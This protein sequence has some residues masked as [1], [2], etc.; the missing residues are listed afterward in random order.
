MAGRHPASTASKSVSGFDPTTI[1]GC[2]LWLDG[3]EPNTLESYEGTIPA[4]INDP[5]SIWQNKSIINPSEHAS[6]GG[7]TLPLR[8]S[9]NGVFFTG[10]SLLATTIVPIGTADVTYFTV[11]KAIIKPANNTAGGIIISTGVNNADSRTRTLYDYSDSVITSTVGSVIAGGRTYIGNNAISTYPATPHPVN[12][13]PLVT[14]TH[15]TTLCVNNLVSSLWVS[16]KPGNNT[17]VDLQDTAKA[18][19]TAN[20]DTIIGG[21][22]LESPIAQSGM[23]LDYYVG[24]IYE[25]L[26]YNSALSNT[27]RQMVE[28]Y[29]AFKW[30]LQEQLPA[31]HPYKNIVR[32]LTRVF[33][34]INIDGCQ[35]W[36]DPSD[37]NTVSLNGTGK[38]VTIKDKSGLGNDVANSSS[39]IEVSTLNG[40]PALNFPA[41]GSNNNLST[42]VITRNPTKRTYFFVIKYGAFL[43]NIENILIRYEDRDYFRQ[44]GST[45]QPKTLDMIGDPSGFIADI[46]GYTG[47]QNATQT[48]DES[49]NSMSAD[50]F[51]GNQIFVLCCVRDGEYYTFSTNGVSADFKGNPIGDCPTSFSYIIS[52]SGNSLVGDVII[53]NAAL[54]KSDLIK[55]EGYLMWKWGVRREASLRI[56]IPSKHP[57]YNFPPDSITPKHPELLLYKKEFNPS[58]LSPV[59]WIDPQDISKT[60][61]ISSG[62]VVEIKNKG[63]SNLTFTPPPDID[64]PL[65]TQSGVKNGVGLPFLDFSN[66]GNFFVSG[67]QVLADGITLEL[68]TSTPH[69][70]PV[71]A[72]V[73]LTVSSGKYADDADATINSGPFQIVSGTTELRPA[74]SGPKGTPAGTTTTFKTVSNNVFLGTGSV[75][76][77]NRESYFFDGTSATGLIS[78][79]FSYIV[80]PGTTDSFQISSN[81]TNPFGVMDI[82]DVCARNNVGTTGYY[83]TIAGTTASTIRLTLYSERT[84]GLLKN[85]SASI[86]YGQI[87]F[88]SVNYTG[89]SATIST[90]INHGIPNGATV[91]V[92]SNNSSY[93]PFQTSIKS[94]P[95][96]NAAYC[97]SKT[98]SYTTVNTVIT[99]V[100][101]PLF[102]GTSGSR[103]YTG[104]PV[105]VTLFAG[106]VI[107]NRTVGS[108]TRTVNAPETYFRTTLAGSDAT[109]VV[110]EMIDQASASSTMTINGFP[111]TVDTITVDTPYNSNYINTTATVS[112]PTS[113][114]I[115]YPVNRRLGTESSGRL[116]N[117]NPFSLADTAD[118]DHGYIMYPVK[119]YALENLALGTALNTSQM[120]IIWASCLRQGY[121]RNNFSDPNT[122]SSVISAATT[123]RAAG[124]GAT[125][126]RD[127]R[128]QTSSRRINTSR[129]SI[130]RGATGGDSSPALV[131]GGRVL[132]S[133]D[134]HFR[135]NNVVMNF[136]SSDVDDVPANT[137]GISTNGWG[138][139]PRFQN[140]AV[141]ASV[142]GQ[143]NVTLVPSHL[144]I[145][146]NTNVIP[147]T[148][149]TVAGIGG[150]S[151]FTAGVTGATAS[152]LNDLTDVLV[153]S[154]GNMYIA[155][156]TN[157]RVRMV[158]AVDGTYFGTTM[159]ANLMYTI[160]GTGVAGFLGD[161]GSAISARLNFPSRVALDSA[162]NLYIADRDNQ[163]IRRVNSVNGVITTIAGNGVTGFGGDG[164]GATGAQLNTPV[165]VAVDSSGNTLIADFGNHRIRRVTTSGTI[166]TVAGIT[167][168]GYNGDSMLAINARLN[169]PVAVAVDHLGHIYIADRDNNRIRRI[170]P[171]GTIFTAAGGASTTGF[172]GDGLLATSST[173]RLNGPR[174]V[175][176]DAQRNIYIADLQNHR[177]RMVPANTGRFFGQNMNANFIYTIA[178]NGSAAFSGDGGTATSA[179]IRAPNGVSVDSSGNVYIADT[180]NHCVREVYSL[181]YRTYQ[182]TSHWYEGGLGDIMVFNSV[183]TF[184]QRKLVEG[185]LAEKY[186]C[187]EFLGT[188]TTGATGEFL[189]PYRTTPTSISPT[190]NLTSRYSQGLVAWFDAANYDTFSFVGGSV[191]EIESW[192]SAGGNLP[193]TL[194]S[195]SPRRPTFQDQVLYDMPGVNFNLTEATAGVFLGSPIGIL[196]VDS[197]HPVT[198]F[199]TL[200]ENNEYTIIV[201]YKQNTTYFE[202][203]MVSNILSTS[204]GN[205]RL[206]TLTSGFTYYVSAGSSQTNTYS[207]T[208]L[209][210]QA[211]IAVNYRRGNLMYARRN[212][213]LDTGATTSGVDLNITANNFGLTLGAFSMGFPGTNAFSGRIF[214][215][216]IFRYA[217]SD[218]EILQIEGYLAGKWKLMNDLPGVHPYKGIRI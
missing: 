18:V 21:P 171:A 80:F 190:V 166:S 99:V 97:L 218:Q 87:P 48:Y 57:F 175:A 116:L 28:G 96:A 213:V 145:G 45:N 198:R 110:V 20:E 98:V 157:H 159:V 47:N 128:I 170:N 127:F 111:L 201:V 15:I 51:F 62:R 162:G 64:G 88:T 4:R 78:G 25:I 141:R 113:T 89:T 42:P 155:D 12:T 169:G 16:G 5:V 71:G 63:T 101:N 109:T 152:R 180:A 55:V 8:S 192:R 50:G 108:T 181:D 135:I 46:P 179:A 107:T 73:T 207:P 200:S 173:V 56:Q 123:T 60:T 81:G 130:I 176:V 178:G 185:Y 35:L 76:V 29:L 10:S 92:C 125:G 77:T 204:T 208:P 168:A 209:G 199:S 24:I 140:L 83:N 182:L 2:V 163:R 143:A 102:T 14:Q 122:Q 70:I 158:P 91:G 132:T 142:A 85:L 197:I 193:L 37:V 82:R 52:S 133:N 191:D 131:P 167:G 211:Y 31:D 174:A 32:P 39:S 84:P 137:Q 164:A 120:T 186:R 1:S 117:I 7:S 183:L 161:G 13:E 93:M 44:N 205:S 11:T 43:E 41:G 115:T 194:Q 79:E 146:A 196:S 177:I 124:G 19:N 129:I 61:A 134:S 136:T 103:T 202:N 22:R 214:E 148:I 90:P 212:G 94:S 34:P 6:N 112:A 3:A 36:L 139:A 66:G 195:S 151:G 49:F 149:G 69:Q 17:N 23:T 58:D 215:H 188:T 150:S 147:T 189:H 40:V 156:R 74:G 210:G 30:E 38:V 105:R 26:V 75:S 65:L 86:N 72:F 184:E 33:L 54:T 59:I 27:D 165:G 187:R 217:L 121:S 144:R 153:D 95:P 53:Y 68:A 114:S 206:S 106:T 203:R 104:I 118:I 67:G 126:G 160:A 119:G 9:D 216:I 100:S 172:A 154:S 138:Y